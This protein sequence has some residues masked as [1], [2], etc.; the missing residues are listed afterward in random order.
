MFKL[1][2]SGAETVIH[3]FVVAVMVYLPPLAC[4]RPLGNLYGATNPAATHITVQY[5]SSTPAAKKPFSTASVAQ[6]AVSQK[7]LWSAI[8][9]AICTA[10][11]STAV[12]TAG[13]WFSK[14][15]R[16]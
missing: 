9:R 6:M 5:S 13:A 8:R 15:F 7:W 3:S 11:L 12:H 14:S 10:P 1:D 16:S 4:S 2:L